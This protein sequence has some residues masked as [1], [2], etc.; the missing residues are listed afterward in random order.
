[1]SIIE[2]ANWLHVLLQAGDA[3]ELPELSLTISDVLVISTTLAI[4]L[5]S[6]ISW[7]STTQKN[8]LDAQGKQYEMQSKNLKEAYDIDRRRLNSLLKK[9]E[10]DIKEL[11]ER[12]RRLESIYSAEFL[13][14]HTARRFFDLLNIN[15]T[16]LQNQVQNDYLRLENGHFDSESKHVN[17]EVCDEINKIKE[18]CLDVSAGLAKKRSAEETA[19]NWLDSNLHNLVATSVSYAL[20]TTDRIAYHHGDKALRKL[21]ERDVEALLKRSLWCCLYRGKFLPDT[22]LKLNLNRNELNHMNYVVEALQFIK[23]VRAPEELPS[24][25]SIS[26]QGFLEDLISFLI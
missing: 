25:A 4:P 22:V 11:H 9:Q 19:A 3:I 16:H 6:A 12:A 14:P 2:S 13:E 21:L 24:G 10:D 8:N 1:M 15:L 17:S 20:Y 26:L 7:I 5:G 23:R 18:Y